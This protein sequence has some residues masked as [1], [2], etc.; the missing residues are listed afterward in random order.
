MLPIATRRLLER[1]TT[2]PFVERHASV[3]AGDL[4]FRNY[5]QIGVQ[6][7]AE[8]HDRTALPLF[9]L[10]DKVY[11]PANLCVPFLIRYQRK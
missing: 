1:N 10:L 4:L 3:P 9:T 6:A 11:F 7:V 2:A 5:H 8:L